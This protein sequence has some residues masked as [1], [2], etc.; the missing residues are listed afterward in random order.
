MDLTSRRR[1]IQTQKNILSFLPLRIYLIVYCVYIN[2]AFVC[3]YVCLKDPWPNVRWNSGNLAE[4]WEKDYRNRKG[5]GHHK[6][7]RRIN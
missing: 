5:Q 3:L 4:E 7:A 2:H 6:K 1:Y